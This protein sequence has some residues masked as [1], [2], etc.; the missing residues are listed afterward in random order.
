MHT[1]LYLWLG[2]VLLFTFFM[3]YAFWYDH[4]ERINN[5]QEWVTAFT[6]VGI[7]P[8]DMAHDEGVWYYKGRSTCVG[9]G[10]WNDECPR[11]EC[12]CAGGKT[13]G[14]SITQAR[15][16]KKAL[17]SGGTHQGCPLMYAGAD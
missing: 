16:I 8:R 12:Y 15:A 3:G 5:S 1:H 7:N 4:K 9:Y 14:D 2:G 10:D 11:H 6:S 17:E 13:F